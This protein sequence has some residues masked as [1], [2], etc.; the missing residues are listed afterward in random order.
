MAKS[1]CLRG[2]LLLDYLQDKLPSARRT[3][4]DTHLALCALCRSL[5]CAAAESL[6]LQVRSS[7]LRQRLAKAD[8]IAAAIEGAPSRRLESLLA[9]CE[10]AENRFVAG[11]LL[12]RSRQEFDRNPRKALRLARAVVTIGGQIGSADVAFEGWRDCASLYL[13]LGHHHLAFEAVE[14]LGQLAA[15]TVDPAHARGIVLYASAYV[16]AD[17]DV[18]RIDEALAFAEQA[19]EIFADTDE[20]RLRATTELRA[21]I[22]HSRGEHAA[23]VEISRRLWQ[24]EKNAGFAIN[25]GCYLVA[26]SQPDA[27]E[28]LLEWGRMHVKDESVLLA[29][30][31][32]L[33]GRLRG[34]QARWREASLAFSRAAGFY[35]VAEMPD[36]AIQADLSRIRAAVNARRD[37]PSVYSDALAELRKLVAESV[38]LDRL[39]PSRRRRFT[40]EALDYARELGEAAALSADLLTYVDEYVELL[41]RSPARPFVRPVPAQLM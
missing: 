26:N 36:T 33:E 27:A 39:Q 34:A 2:K 14:R 22:H 21:A 12:E 37:E 28:S 31:G 18:W 32:C 1:E 13:R 35:R 4:A 25:Y 23:A 41:W 30:L 3:A 6:R 29:R 40:A 9:E 5:A 7:E 17:R 38:A 10:W 24:S 11:R 19:A 15:R 16:A 8:E 20:R